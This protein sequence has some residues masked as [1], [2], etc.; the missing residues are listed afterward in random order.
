MVWF[1]AE[2]LGVENVSIPWRD[3]TV[4]LGLFLQRD[5]GQLTI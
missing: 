5:A 2:L 4:E 1:T 3:L